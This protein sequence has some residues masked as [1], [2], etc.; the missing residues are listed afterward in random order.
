MIILSFSVSATNYYVNNNASGTNNGSDWNNAWES[1]ADIAWGSINPGDY[2]YV[3]GGSTN[4]TYN[5][6]LVVG[7]SGNATHHITIK[8]GQDTGHNGKAIIT[9]STAFY[10]SIK[11]EDQ[12]DIIIDG[13]VEN[14]TGQ[15][16]ILKGSDAGG[17]YVLDNV[18][19][20]R[21]SYLDIYNNSG[22]GINIII[23]EQNGTI[24]VDN[25]KIHDNKA[26]I[27]VTVTQLWIHHNADGGRGNNY[28]RILIHDN[29]IFDFSGDAVKLDFDGVDFY[30]NEVFNRSIRTNDHIDGIQGNGDWRYWRIYNN[31]FHDFN[32]LDQEDE[33]NAWIRY[34]DAFGAG[35]N[36]SNILIYNNIFEE[37]RPPPPG[38]VFRGLEIAIQAPHVN[39]VIVANNVLLGNP[40]NSILIDFFRSVG[41]GYATDENTSNV[42]VANNIIIDSSSEAGSTIGWDLGTTSDNITIGSFGD[43]V[44]FIVDNNIIYASNASYSTDMDGTSYSTAKSNSGVQNND[45]GSPINPDLN[46]SYYPYTNSSAIDA[47]F[48]LSTYFT[49]DFDGVTRSQGLGWDIGVFESNYTAGVCENVSVLCVNW[50][51]SAEY[52]TVQSAANVASAGDTVLVYNGYY[53]ESVTF[54]NNGNITHPLLVKAIDNDTIVRRFDINRNYVTIEGFTLTGHTVAYQGTVN[55]R[56]TVNNIQIINNSFV[57]QSHD[58]YSVYF[59]NGG[60]NP[61]SSASDCLIKDNVFD[62]QESLINSFNASHMLNLMGVNNTVENNVFKYSA[63][64]DAIRIF[65]ANHTIRNNTFTHI[66]EVPYNGN[67]ADIIQTFGSNGHASYGHVFENNFVY[68]CAE[69][70]LGQ[71][72]Q[73][74]GPGGTNCTNRTDVNGLID[75]ITGE[76]ITDTSQS[77]SVDNWNDIYVVH[78]LNGSANGAIYLIKDTQS[79]TLTLSHI[80]NSIANLTNDGVLAG[81]YYQ[82]HTRIGWMTFRN[83]IYVNMGYLAGGDFNNVAPH[84]Y[85]YN[86]IF[87][88]STS[89]QPNVLDFARHDWGIADHAII[90]NNVFLK[91]GNVPSNPTRGFYDFYGTRVIDVGAPIGYDTSNNYFGGPNYAEKTINES[92]AVNG[93]NPYFVNEGGITKQDW[94]LLSNST[95]IDSGATITTFNYD[96]FLTTRPQGSGWDIGAYEF[97]GNAS[98]LPIYSNFNGATTNFS[99]HNSS[100]IQNV[101]SLVLEIVGFGKIEFNQWVN[102]SG[103]NLDRDVLIQNKLIGVDS[104]LE[105]RL[106]KSATITFYNIEYS[107]PIVYKDGVVFTTYNYTLT[108][109]NL[110][111]NVS[112]FSNFT[113]GSNANLTIFDDTDGTTKYTGEI[114]T[115]YANYTNSTSGSLITGASCN[116][117]FNG[118][119]FSMN[120]TPSIYEYNNTFT[121]NG[122]YL[123]NVTCAK[124][125]FDTL[126]LTDNYVINSSNINCNN[127]SDCSSKLQNSSNE[128]STVF[129]AQDILNYDGDC[130][131]FG[132]ADNINFSCNGFTLEGIG[133]NWNSEGILASNSDNVAIID[134]P[135]IT[136]WAN[137]IVVTNADSVLVRNVSTINNLQA[138]LDLSTDNSVYESINSSY[139]GQRGIYLTYSDG[140]IVNNTELKENDNYDLDFGTNGP[141]DCDNTFENISISGDRPLGFYNDTVNLQ[142]QEYSL[143][144]L[145]DADNSNLTN[146]TVKGSNALNNNYFKT[147]FVDNSTFTNINSSNNYEGVYIYYSNNNTFDNIIANN[148]ADDGIL[149]R[150]SQDNNISNATL[151]NNQYGFRFRGW[152]DPSTN[153]IIR[154]SIVQ[155][156]TNSS[157]NFLM[158]SYAVTNNYFYN[159]IFNS[160]LNFYSDNINHSPNYFN[161]TLTVGTNIIGGSNI[162]GNF[163][164]QPNGQGWSENCSDSNGDG[165]CEAQYDLAINNTDYLPLTLNGASPIITLNNPPNGSSI[166]NNYQLLNATV[167]SEGNN[168]I[169][170]KLLGYY[171]DEI[172][173]SEETGLVFLMHL[174]NNSDIGENDTVFVD[175]SGLGNNGTC[176]DPSLTNWTTY[177]P[178]LNT[179]GKFYNSYLFDGENQD[180]A[181]LV[182]DDPT[183]SGLSEITV[184]VW[185][186]PTEHPVDCYGIS[187]YNTIVTKGN[188]TEDR[189]FRLRYE[190]VGDGFNG[191]VWHVSGNG[192]DPDTNETRINVSEV[193]LNEWHHLVGTWTNTTGQLRFYLDGT[194]K[195]TDYYSA[196]SIFDG[197]AHLAIGSSSDNGGG[198]ASPNNIDD[199]RGTIDEVAIYNRTLSDQEIF[200]IY[201][202]GRHKILYRAQNLSNGTEIN[203]NLT[204]IP[205]S[206]NKDMVLLMHFDNDSSKGE[207]NTFVYDW[208]GLGNKGTCSGS[209]CPAMNVSG[210]KFAGAFEY[211]GS[212]D[213]IKIDDDPMLDLV[214]N[215]TISAWINPASFGENN[216]GRIVDKGGGGGDGWSF[217]VDNNT[218]TNA[219]SLQIDGAEFNSNNNSIELNKWQLVTVTLE[220][221]T[222]SFYVDGVF[223]NSVDTGGNEPANPNDYNV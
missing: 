80:N 222:G 129:L 61:S 166:V 14:G 74:C 196:S 60:T 148:N 42:I 120:E 201:D 172:N 128:N 91:S 36:I 118:T 153:N 52:T 3:S 96:T 88:N 158:N 1:F 45:A 21:L 62:N 216:Q 212:D 97:L 107:N 218:P 214:G 115:F 203:Y 220:G 194:L 156:A 150:D 49:N 117:T 38:T 70:Q 59:A 50:D 13:R 131:E 46:I 136:G 126:N 123:F 133:S 19:N 124:T 149:L 5:S 55:I 205:L 112:S 30:D 198:G 164:A 200:R 98:F 168:S 41:E 192:S 144:I 26:G 145:C 37:T 111:L 215:F 176:G 39:T 183:I 204:S 40:T 171:A 154:D 79:D 53:D 195:H 20:I 33:Y 157:I 151:I 121:T 103:A 66:E 81:D 219:L 160:T 58:I 94:M 34:G 76:N 209:V 87:Y 178:T 138:G 140:N 86:N 95:L 208:T 175:E 99:S 155:N 188:Y 125:G 167:T 23:R 29:K 191:Y 47:G 89:T 142:D 100:S 223:I 122:T 65:G 139:N 170:A 90:K 31:Y 165:I 116:I 174:N 159:N 152:N 69:V 48:N 9:D 213:Y 110:S 169:T 108:G 113:A 101:S 189:E 85:W 102:V 12:H 163:W 104:V 75:S 137:G 25:S 210:G 127:C 18:T 132:G 44:S 57:N 130:V 119:W 177:C 187:C 134:C 141:Q 184:S 35:N 180:E 193:S 143:L 56:D 161:T 92:N 135:N 15:N 105:P 8:V 6:R 202:K 17:V 83:N 51:G 114:V 16:F 217:H 185:I 173:P 221:S 22:H 2:I 54:N 4:K 77:W 84:M 197:S 67:H 11:I 190:D 179:N 106:N 64:A 28:S 63:G 146:I 78:I 72:T 199:Y 73:D 181:I 32:R 82:I 162:G 93:S 109:T 182:L 206:V 186:Y 211:D 10:T 24:Q 43:N 71:V 207:N 7:A 27:N 68:D 147:L